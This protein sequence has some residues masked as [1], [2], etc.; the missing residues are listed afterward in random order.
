MSKSAK[1]SLS[2][3]NVIGLKMLMNIRQII[4]TIEW[5]VSAGGIK[6]K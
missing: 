4:H 3:Y 2:S 6:G 1:C 5:T